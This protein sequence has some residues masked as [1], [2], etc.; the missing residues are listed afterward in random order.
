M[1]SSKNKPR[2]SYVVS[3]CGIMCGLALAM[4]FMLS[5]IPSFEYV[6]PAAAGLLIWVVYERLGVK[7]GLVSYLAVG[8]LCM[9][10]TPNLE[11]AM[12]Y[13]FLL[14]YYPIIRQYVMRLK[15]AVPRWAAKLAIYAAASSVCYLVLINLFGMN[16]LLEDFNEFG[17]YGSLVLLGMGAVAFVAYDIFLGLFFPFYE[18]LLKPKIQK[19]M[20]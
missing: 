10:F 16:Q 13:V 7:Y 18:K 3:L 4:M 20:K 15:H 9:F 11:A 19:R 6:S 12:M 8:I 14:G 5:M 2:I 1:S 17:K